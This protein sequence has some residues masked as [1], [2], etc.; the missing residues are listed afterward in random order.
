MSQRIT[1][2]HFGRP[3]VFVFGEAPELIPGPGQV[4][5]RTRIASVNPTDA[6]VRR[7]E[8]EA[9]FPS[10]FPVCPGVDVAGVIDAVGADVAGLAV[11]D[12]VFGMAASGSYAEYVLM[13]KPVAKP[14]AV[15]WDV[16]A[17]L[18]TA[19]ETAV[20]AYRAT[21]VQPGQTLLV[22][23]AAGGIGSIVT[24]LAVADRVTVVGTVGSDDDDVLRQLGGV[25][26]RY[27][28]G[29]AHRVGAAAPDGVDAVLDTAGR[30]VLPE[31]VE[32]TGDPAR[33]VTLVDPAAFELG[34][35]FTGIDPTDRAEDA[36]AL[37]A[38]VAAQGHLSV[39]IWR[40]YPLA[41]AAQ[42]HRD[43]EAG[44]NRGKILLTTLDENHA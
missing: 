28:D 8:M 39:P 44:A 32:L 37:L 40:T 36:L 11:G 5:V 16:A 14:A 23:G 10:T 30:G 22:H 1:Y 21:T 43:L 25:P 12:E 15:S 24:Q 31:S 9:I 42:A 2:D 19:G 26:V 20:R 4:R 34:A 17:A 7:G 3:D 41:H 18:P 35:V 27:G 13:D 6:K 33:V 29:W 38:G